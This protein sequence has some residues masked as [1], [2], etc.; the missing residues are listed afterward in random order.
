MVDRVNR[1]APAFVGSHI[2]TAR[3]PRAVRRSK[4][5]IQE[6]LETPGALEPSEESAASA[7]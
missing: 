4:D 3:P 1:A 5:M 6:A 2:K 7:F